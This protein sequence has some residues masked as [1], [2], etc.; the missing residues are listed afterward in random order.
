MRQSTI[1]YRNWMETGTLDA[2]RETHLELINRMKT[3]EKSAMG[4]L[5]YNLV[6]V[7]ANQNHAKL[8]DMYC[9]RYG[10]HPSQENDKGEIK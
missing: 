9:A 8:T 6:A 3:I 4:I 5:E 1:A 2:D 10:V 7:D